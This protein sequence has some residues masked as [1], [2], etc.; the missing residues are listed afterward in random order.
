MCFRYNMNKKN[1]FLLA[2]DK[3]ISNMHLKQA[4]LLNYL[5]K[6]KKRYKSLKKQEIQDMFTQ[7][8]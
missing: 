3:L 5:L 4:V 1:K 6:T 7:A 2:G 8:N